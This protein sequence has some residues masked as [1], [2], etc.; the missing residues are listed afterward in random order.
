MHVHY[1]YLRVQITLQN[2]KKNHTILKNLK[3]VVQTLNSYD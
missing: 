1:F 2:A 3:T